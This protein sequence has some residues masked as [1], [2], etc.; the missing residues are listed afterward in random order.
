MQI[1]Q[2]NEWLAAQDRGWTTYSVEVMTH[3]D[4]HTSELVIDSIW[5]TQAETRQRV[6]ALLAEGVHPANIS[7]DECRRMAGRQTTLGMGVLA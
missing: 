6:R 1:Q 7:V 2:G 3:P 5:T 4:D